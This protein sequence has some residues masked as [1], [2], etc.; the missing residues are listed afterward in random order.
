M[1]KVLIV[2][3][4]HEGPG[5]LTK[6]LEENGLDHDLIILNKGDK[7]PSPKDY[8]AMIVLGGPDSANDV[9]EKM[10]HELERIREAIDGKVPYLGI[11]LGLQTLVKAA[12]GLV[13][14]NPTREIGFRD[15]DGNLFS[16]EVVENDELLKDLP[17]PMPVFQLHGETVVT[18]D[19]MKLLARGKL[20]ENQIVRVAPKQ[21]GIQCH[22]ELTNEMFE[23]WL[24]T[25]PDL[26]LQDA[27]QNRRDFKSIADAYEKTGKQLF[28][29]FINI[30]LK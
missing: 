15:P 6:I 27:E 29:N 1:N 30:A 7:I 28:L 11:C 9:T 18:T 20:C 21:Y 3:N 4:S 10:L 25:D 17:T 13:V 22:F 24:A 23:D 8:A 5:L 19:A 12:G 26:I 14:K 2:Q 16:V